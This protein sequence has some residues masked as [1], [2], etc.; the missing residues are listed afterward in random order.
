LIDPDLVDLSL[1]T[2]DW[3]DGTRTSGVQLQQGADGS[4]TFSALHDYSG[5]GL[6][7]VTLYV[8]DG[9]ETVTASLSAKVS[10][11]KV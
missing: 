4:W 6:Y 8:N 9:T 5:G 11:A 1:V 10:G 3:G 2:I 7:T